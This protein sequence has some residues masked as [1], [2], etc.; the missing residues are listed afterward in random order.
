MVRILLCTDEPILAAGLRAVIEPN[1]T[2]EIC[3]VCESALLVSSEVERLAPD[4]LVLQ[5]GPEVNVRLLDG[6][7]RTFPD[8]RTV[9]WAREV[10][11]SLAAQAV[12][13][14][15]AGILRYS[16]SLELVERCLQ[17]VGAG[18]SWFEKDLILGL[19]SAKT[20]SLTPRER[21]LVRLLSQGLSNKE[22]GTVLDLKESTVK[23]YLSKLYRKAGVSDRLELALIG[24]RNMGMGQLGE[25][26]APGDLRSIVVQPPG[27]EE[28][29]PLKKA[30]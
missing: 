12:N 29:W 4:L 13:L 1:R 19:L 25:D 2:L 20:I 14:G 30:G 11:L 24:I 8:C 7:R 10:S 26:A 21:Q 5:A 9:L 28:K 18:E 16:M 27:R 23:V 3:G 22:I 17:R 15:L 6:L